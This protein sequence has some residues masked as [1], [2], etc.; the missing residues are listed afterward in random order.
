M[1]RDLRQIEWAFDMSCEGKTYPGYTDD[2][3]WNGFLN[4]VITP[5]TRGKVVA[6]LRARAAMTARIP[7]STW[8]PTRRA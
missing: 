8:P 4:V 1:K 5:E 2:S 7:L 6:D 3:H